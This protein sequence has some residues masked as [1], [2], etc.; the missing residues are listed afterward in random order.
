MFH[1]LA[2]LRF[3]LVLAFLLVSVPPMLA[4]AYVATRLIAS[5]F[6]DNVEQWLGETSKYLRLQVRDS[7]IESARLA[8]ILSIRM[9]ETHFLDAPDSAALKG[10]LALAYATGYD[11]IAVYDSQRQLRFTSRAFTST[12]RL[13]LLAQDVLM[14]VRQ[15][16]SGKLL[17]GAT[18]KFTDHGDSFYVLVGSW[19]DDESLGGIKIVSSLD[20]RLYTRDADTLVP[21][22]V[23]SGSA[24]DAIAL[25]KSIIDRLIAK[26]EPV[27]D[28]NEDSA[29]YRAVYAGL[30]NAGGDMVAV[31]FCGL[32][33]QESFFPRIGGWELFLGMFALGSLLSVLA[34]LWM[35]GLLVRPLKALSLG[36]RSV[37]SGDYQQRVAVA[38]GT[39]VEEL[40]ASFNSMAAQLSALK[41]LE[42][43]LRRNDRL[44]A[45][46]EA[47]MVI[48]HEVRNPLG[49]IQTSAELVRSKARLAPAEDKLLGYVVDEVRRIEG[50]IR[51]FLDFALPKP[52][53]K[54]RVELRSVLRRAAAFAALELERR[55]ISFVLDDRAPAISI[56]GDADQLYQAVLNL[57]LNAMDAMPK[58]GVLTG[59]IERD[60][61]VCRLTIADTGEGVPPHVRARLFDPFFTTKAKGSGL[62]LA[63]VRTVAEAHGGAAEF[64]EV[65]GGGSAFTMVL[66]Q[67]LAQT[68]AV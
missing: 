11:L 64:A 68:H 9:P 60:G 30:R 1:R 62:G 66:G 25:P 4:A 29:T 59:R 22:F 50:L 17:A 52:P 31:V 48:A 37:T 55:R 57:V 39:E 63:K 35:S 15:G 18:Q 61:P 40:A 12:A 21:V 43:D 19:V 13:P 2:S 58:G 34:G 3:R 32:A 24:S 46:G 42:S 20:L 27:Y 67:L 10:E 28:D 36:V 51:E 33:R 14:T 44:K 47:A 38:G 54:I 49:I 41:G 56:A 16:G 7:Q 8:Q 65:A 26:D 5:A 23:T 45:L 6:E 53:Q